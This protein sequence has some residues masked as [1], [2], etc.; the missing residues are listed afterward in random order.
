MNH[1]I[2]IVV[3]VPSIG[4]EYEMYIPE[5]KKI[6]SIRKLIISLIEEM[7]NY[8]FTD[9]GCKNLYYQ[10]TGEKLDDNQFVK[11][12][13]IKNGTKLILYYEVLWK[14]LLLKRAI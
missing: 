12:S 3:Q 9:D 13:S 2:Y 8:N 14:L 10:S 6:G 4:E 5:V 1:K 11:Y 7:S